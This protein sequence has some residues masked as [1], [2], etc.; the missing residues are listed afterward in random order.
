MVRSLLRVCGVLLSVVCC[1]AELW[2][3]PAEISADWKSELNEHIPA[4]GEVKLFRISGSNTIGAHLAPSLVSTFFAAEGL[5]NIEEQPVGENEI[6]VS[7]VWNGGSRPLKL[8]VT[9][10]A[11]GSSTGFKALDLGDA[12]LAASSRP[13]NAG[14]LLT[15]AQLG[16][17]S[18]SDHE[19][20]IAID[21]LA[22][23]V[24]PANPLTQLT[25]RQITDLFT[26]KIRSWKDVGGA[27]AP[28]RIYARDD[29]SGTY[30]T[31]ERLVL[32][33]A[34][35]SSQAL[36]FESNDLLARSVMADANGIGF[37]PLANVAATKALRVSDGVALG[38][39]PTTLTVATEDYPLSRRLYFYA[40]DVGSRSAALSAFLAFV[41]TDAGQTVVDKVG[42]VAQA[43]HPVTVEPSDARLQ[44]WQRLN[45][46]IRFADGSSD[47][48]NKAR[49]DV[50]R[51]VEY[52]DQHA[53]GDLQLTLVGY[54]NP[55]TLRNQATLSRL[56]AQNVRWALRDKGVRGKLETL[57]GAAVSVADPASINADRNRRVEV[58]VR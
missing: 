22:I 38:L 24:N 15:L 31:F 17:M 54:S 32:R 35:L 44:R 50:A 6:A 58:W 1:S 10:A 34:A 5:T 40:A 55:A 43:L 4:S 48:D 45:L 30:D 13:I 41:S 39:A 11:H 20:I 33:G 52:L 21:G 49:A 53:A 7:G 26:G 3:Q 27:S 18:D 23:I 56:R 47:L 2:A 16:N 9:V 42:F 36:R 29:Q 51:L 8:V 28:V 25:T 19:H 57:A 46:N 37:V 14:E 12:D